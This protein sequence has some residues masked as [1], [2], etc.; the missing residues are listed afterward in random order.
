MKLKECK[1]AAGG[2][3]YHPDLPGVTV[4]FSKET[5]QVAGHVPIGDLPVVWL[6]DRRLIKYLAYLSEDHGLQFIELI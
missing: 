6:T 2:D 1:L 5:V 4:K 3:L